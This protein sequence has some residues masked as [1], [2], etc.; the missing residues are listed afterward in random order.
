MQRSLL[1]ICFLLL[2]GPGLQAAPDTLRVS[3]NIHDI[4]NPFVYIN[5]F[6]INQ[7]SN[8][9]VFGN[10]RGN[11]A[12][13]C[14]YTDTIVV[15]ADGYYSQRITLRD[16][17]KNRDVKQLRLKVGLRK[18][19]IVLK[20]VDIIPDRTVDEIK[21]DLDNAKDPSEIDLVTVDPVQSPLTALYQAF[22]KIE[23]SKYKVAVMEAED[24]KREILRELLAKYVKADIISLNEAQFDAFISGSNF[25]LAAIRTMND[26]DLVVYVKRE[27]ERYRGSY[28]Y[29]LNHD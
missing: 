8:K 28:N 18:K 29:Y 21:E 19:E 17:V 23:R 22:S 11:F 12:M 7:R 3:G 26:Y 6:V 20:P 15:S 25:D 9:G 27:Y 4:D 13:I 14:M 10:S 1:V 2:T 16:S 24:R 5:Y